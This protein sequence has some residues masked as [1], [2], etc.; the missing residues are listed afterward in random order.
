V[1]YKLTDINASS[2]ICRVNICRSEGK[3]GTLGK[4]VTIYYK[5]FIINYAVWYCIL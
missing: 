4:L 3:C 5:Y 1:L 2:N